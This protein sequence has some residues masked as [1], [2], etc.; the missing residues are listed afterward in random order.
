MKRNEMNEEQKK[1]ND[2]LVSIFEKKRDRYNEINR[3][4]GFTKFQRYMAQKDLCES[5]ALIMNNAKDVELAAFYKK[6]AIGFEE[7]ARKLSIG[8]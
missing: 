6:S 8:A 2:L 1:R 5:M 7:R 4:A 3:T